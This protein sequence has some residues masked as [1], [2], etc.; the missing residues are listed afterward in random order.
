MYIIFGTDVEINILVI[1]SFAL[2]CFIFSKVIKYFF[3]F[4]TS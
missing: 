2:S 4:E 1:L 3:W